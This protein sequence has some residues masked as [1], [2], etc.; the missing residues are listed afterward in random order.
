MQFELKNP[1]RYMFLDKNYFQENAFIG[2]GIEKGHLKL[3]YSPDKN[4]TFSAILWNNRIS[5]GL[6]HNIRLKFSPISI[7]I[8]KTSFRKNIPLTKDHGINLS[9]GRFFLGNVPTNKSLSYETNGFFRFPFEGCIDSFT[10]NSERINDFT[11]FEG[12]GIDICPVF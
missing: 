3:A 11:L 12:L 6:W 7:E 10:E 4:N 9:N 1:L 2:L 8:D 5:D